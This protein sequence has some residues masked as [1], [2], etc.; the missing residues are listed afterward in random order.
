MSEIRTGSETKIRQFGSG[1]G[2][3]NLS[4][5]RL[6]WITAEQELTVVAAGAGCYKT[7]LSPLSLSLSLDMY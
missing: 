7:H 5:L 2:T 3:G 1:D 6:I 4:V